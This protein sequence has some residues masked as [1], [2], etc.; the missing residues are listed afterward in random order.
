MT[1]ATLQ[2]FCTTEGLTTLAS[3]TIFSNFY[4]NTYFGIYGNAD[5]HKIKVILIK[6]TF[7]RIG[8]KYK[9]Q[10]TLVAIRYYIIQ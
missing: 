5:Y 3:Y 8:P 7:Q 2:T 9:Y 4:T 1:E 6:I 10:R